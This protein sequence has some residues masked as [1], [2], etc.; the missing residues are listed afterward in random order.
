VVAFKDRATKDAFEASCTHILV[1]GGRLANVEGLNLE[2]VGIHAD[3]QHGIEVDDYLQTH[4]QR[5]FAIG[6]V[7]HRLEFAHAAEREAAIAF[8]NAVLRIPR[9][10]DYESLPW[11]TFTDPEIA[12][13]G[14]SEPAAKAVDPEALVFRAEYDTLDRA[15]I[16]G[17]TD[18]FA[19]VVATSSGKILGASVVGEGASL[20]L[21]EFVLAKEHGLSLA[22]IGAAV[23]TYPTYAGLARNLANQ[24]NAT[25]PES[26]VVKTLRWFRGFK[27]RGESAGVS[28]A[29]IAP[30]V[31]ARHEDGHGH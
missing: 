8:Q 15:R 24:F 19:K 21:Q 13:V 16:E 3:P 2:V 28:A 9:K 6:D 12:T 27:P 4:A 11:T 23:H 25:R 10:M 20:I 30:Q 31:A 7:T 17:A 26:G 29:P 22:D 1:A 14:L 18:G 5:I